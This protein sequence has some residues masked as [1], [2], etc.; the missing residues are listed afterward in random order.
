MDCLYYHLGRMVVVCGSRGEG[1]GT[2]RGE[3]RTRE[4]VSAGRGLGGGGERRG[5]KGRRWSLPAE[6]WGGGGERRGVKGRRE[7][8]LEGGLKGGGGEGRGRGVLKKVF[9]GGRGEEGRGVS[10]GDRWR[11]RRMEGSEKRGEEVL[12]G[13]IEEKQVLKC[14]Y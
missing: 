14:V 2:R 13:C 3:G 9:E 12:E 10:G 5:V 4:G 8:V 1:G 6:G 11:E 7:G